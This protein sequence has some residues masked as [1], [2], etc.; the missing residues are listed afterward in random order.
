MI[1][2]IAPYK[3]N[4]EYRHIMPEEESIIMFFCND[5]L[6]VREKHKDS[7]NNKIHIEFP[8]YKTVKEAVKSP[9]Y[10]FEIDGV[11]YFR[12][13]IEEENIPF[14]KENN[15]VLQNRFY[16]RVVAPKVAAFASLTALHLNGWYENNR[17]CG[18]CGQKLQ[19]STE[20]RMLYCPNCDNM[21]YPKIAPAVIVAVLNK[22]KVLVT[23]YKG[24]E[25]KNYALIAGF[26]EIGE[27]LEATVER[28]VFEEAGVKVKNIRYYKSQP[29]G[30][31]DNILAGYICELDGDDTIT[32]DDNELSVAEW[33]DKKD[34]NTENIDASS[35]TNDMIKYISQMK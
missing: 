18:K 4:N 24:R 3:F 33:M 16:F 8:R 21:V 5:K 26:N 30:M 6:A 7:S 28:E 34:L 15:L 19:N 27:S 32:M 13:Y 9:I 11:S 23:K 29:W 22:E 31:A 17:Y 14:W 2:D 35:L 1:Q 12:Q 10:L 25:Y 20:E